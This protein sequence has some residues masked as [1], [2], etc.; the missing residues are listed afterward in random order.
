MTFLKDK[1]SGL[2]VVPLWIDGRSTASTPSTRFPVVCLEQNNKTVHLAEAAN[3]EAA[4]RAVDSSWKAFQSWKHTP[5]AVRRSVV[6]RAAAL[7][8]DKT[9]ELVNAQRQET[10]VIETWARKNVTLA[11]ELAEEI[12]ACISSVKGEIP[13]TASPGSLGLVLHEPIGP[14]LAIAPY[15]ALIFPLIYPQD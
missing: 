6:Q 12:A 5:V 9:E 2:R 3:S 1:A 10:S 13:P 14:I 15:D 8:L 7:L 4:V 11:A